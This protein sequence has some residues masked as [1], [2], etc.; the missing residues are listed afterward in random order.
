MGTRG[1]A[2][3]RHSTTRAT[4]RDPST[5]TAIAM[6]CV[7]VL[8]CGRHDAARA[9]GIGDEVDGVDEQGQPLHLRIDD[10]ILDADDPDGGPPR[11][12][13]AERTADGGWRPYCGGDVPAIVV[14][15]SWDAR[16]R[17]D[18]DPARTTFACTNGAVAKCVGLGYAPW[19]AV[20]G[21]SL[22][23]ELAACVRMIRA[24]YCGDGGTHTRDGTPIAVWDARGIL[25]RGAQE[26]EHPRFEAAWSPDGAEYLAAPRLGQS[27]TDIVAACP[28]RLRGRTSL[29][30][31]LDEAEVRARFPDARLFDARVLP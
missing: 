18:D 2:M 4:S 11:Y 17:Y 20:D 24:D 12:H 30:L 1:V 8:G 5:T 6:A 21:E 23:P 31:P 19:R 29:E 22:A 27:L 13:F 9:L 3:A 25:R 15:G 14:P 10:V 28:E 7:L 16:G 26:S